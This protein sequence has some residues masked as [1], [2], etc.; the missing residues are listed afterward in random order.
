MK[1][2][3]FRIKDNKSQLF[4]TTKHDDSI[5]QDAL[6][7][8]IIEHKPSLVGTLKDSGLIIKFIKARSWHEYI[9]L[10]WNHSRVTKEVKGSQLLRELGLSVPIIHE[11]GFGVI[12]SRNYRFLGYYIMDNLSH[13]GD[14][15]LSKL[16]KE[17]GINQAMREKLLIS[18][19]DGLKLMRDNRI[20]FTDFHLDNVFANAQGDITWIDTGVT[21]FHKCNHKKFKAKLN[22]SISRFIH[23]SNDRGNTLSPKETSMFEQ[24]LIK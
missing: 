23:Y 14:Q 21:T 22:H 19:Y 4:L 5:Q 11:V 16:I 10:L 7:N 17:N 13:S 12:P 9:K 24:L 18:V 8:I 20:V 15:E 3:T 1:L 6:N 2:S